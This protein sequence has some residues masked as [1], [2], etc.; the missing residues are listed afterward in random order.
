MNTPNPLIPQGSLEA[1]QHQKR[2]ATKI[3]VSAILALH[4][5]VLGGLLFLGCKP[6]PTAQVADSSGFDSLEAPASTAGRGPEGSTPFGDLSVSTNDIVIPSVDTNFH[7]P[8]AAD[9]PQGGTTPTNSNSPFGGLPGNPLVPGTSSNAGF[10]PG[11]ETTTLVR[12]PEPAP[13][14]VKYTVV[15]KD[16]FTTI[17]KKHKITIQAITAANPS[18]DSRKLK[19]GQV[20]NLPANVAPVTPPIPEG[21]PASAA[22][23]EVTYTVKSGDT[24]TKIARDHKVTIKQLQQANAIKGS[25]IRVG[26]KLIVPSVPGSASSQ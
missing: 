21:G 11:G 15:P 14:I 8:F 4:G 9:G 20:L 7:N 13:T 17:A 25:N 24:L 2:S 6:E 26:Q 10:P 1:Q 19:V 3:V 22:S 12:E 18:V 23:S 16:T 5:V